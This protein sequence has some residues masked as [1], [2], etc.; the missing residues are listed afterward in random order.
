MSEEKS[1]K[2]L[3]NKEKEKLPFARAEIIRLMKDELSSDKMISERVKVEMNK[4]LGNILK[5][6]CEELNK[7]PYTT[8]DYEMLKESIY[9][10]TNIKH[11]NQEKMRILAHLNAIKYDCDALSMDVEKTLRL[12]DGKNDESDF[13]PMTS[14]AREE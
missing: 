1:D 3:E 10:Y 8:I 2:G 6:V 9:P 5:E 4:F 14:E 11:I 13:K 7:Y 12:N